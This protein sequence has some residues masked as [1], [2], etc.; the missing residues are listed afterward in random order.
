SRIRSKQIAEDDVLAALDKTA[1]QAQRAGPISRPLRP[2]VKHSEPNRTLSDVSVM[3]S[4]ALELAE[5]ELRRRNVRMSHYVAA[6]LPHLMVEPILIE[7][8]LVNLLRNAAEAIEH[9]GRPPGRRSVE[10]RVVPKQIDVQ[11]VV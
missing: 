9:A 8:V 1:R 10:L 5:I 6:R 11:N 4:E 7:Q 3:V 2:Y